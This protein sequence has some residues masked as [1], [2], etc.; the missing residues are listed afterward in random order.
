MAEM[1]GRRKRYVKKKGVYHL[2]SRDSKKAN[3]EERD[4]FQ[5]GEKSI[6]IISDA[7]SMV[8]KNL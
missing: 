6:A 4:S 7:A 5:N 2:E 3:W 1:T 8:L